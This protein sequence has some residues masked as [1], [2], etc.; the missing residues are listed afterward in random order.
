[1]RVDVTGGALPGFLVDVKR[2]VADRKEL[3]HVLALRFSD[4]LKAHFRKKNQK[5]NR[6]GGSR[7]G[8]WLAMAEATAVERADA[9]GAR[10]TVADQ[11]F[12]IHLY[13]GRIVPKVAK[14]LTIPLVA[15]AHGESVASYVRKT[16]NFLFRNKKETVLMEADGDGVRP[17][18]ALRKSVTIQ[19]DA[20]A[21]PS[22]D[23]LAA[24]IAQEAEDYLEVVLP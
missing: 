17:V 6:L 5:P 14:A 3:H 15:E 20:D 10:V 13:G 22:D 16:G 19:R 21:L 23:Y 4:E 18:Y 2:E 1:M 7:S 8:F 24:A 9:D 11:R 12:N